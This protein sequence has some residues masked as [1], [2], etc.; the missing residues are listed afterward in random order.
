VFALSLAAALAV[1]CSKP[2]ERAPAAPS[3]AAPAALSGNAAN[4]PQLLAQY[5]CNSCHNIPGVDAPKG[6][7]APSLEHSAA[8]AS[9]A[10][11]FPNDAAT[12]A[13]WLQN[14]QSLDPQTTMP[15]LGVTEPD[16]R[17]MTA[18]LFT[19]R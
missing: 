8:K 12:M 4:G 13:R 14:P 10:G 1:A 2:E 6:S 3:T 5:G 17:A 11:K 15:N 9:I 18:Y 16:A 19:L 7:I